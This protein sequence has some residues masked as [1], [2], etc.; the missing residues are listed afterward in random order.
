[1]L[2]ELPQ[3]SMFMRTPLY[4]IGDY[5]VAGLQVAATANGPT[6]LVYTVTPRGALRFD[7]ISQLSY[8]TSELWWAIAQANNIMDP[9]V[10]VSTGTQLR[11]PAR[12]RLSKEGVLNG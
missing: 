9:L 1:M 3:H 7:L 4:A 2:A 5:V 10:G 12:A 11:I 8:G 6:D